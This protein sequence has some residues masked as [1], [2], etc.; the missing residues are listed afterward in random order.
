M[1]P[2]SAMIPEFEYADVDEALDRFAFKFTDGVL[3]WL[4]REE[5]NTAG[6]LTAISELVRSRY[7][8]AK[9]RHEE[10]R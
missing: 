9:R 5:V 6:G 7:R 2:P 10:R 3:V 1:T 8:D 4:D